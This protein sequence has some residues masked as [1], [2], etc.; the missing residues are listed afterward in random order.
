MNII[1]TTNIND[2]FQNFY[3]EYKNMV[4]KRANDITGDYYLAQDICQETF[5]RLYRYRDVV[6]E[7]GMLGWL[8]I[9]A[10]NLAYDH[11]KLSR[12]HREILEEHQDELN[13]YPE[14][15]VDRSVELVEQ[16]AWCEYMLRKL[17]ERNKDWYEIL[18]LNEYL[19]VP[20]RIIAK[21][22]GFSYATVDTYLRR[23]K[24]WLKENFQEEYDRL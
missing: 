10:R 8:L 16:G 21:R 12:R 17:Y 18:L 3:E 19:G 20:K 11:V 14:N 15:A 6:H 23:C 13:K 2:K 22:T 9:V 4:L 5:A 1:D 7:E 24:K